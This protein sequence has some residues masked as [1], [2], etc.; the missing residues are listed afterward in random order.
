[1]KKIYINKFA[2]AEE[3]PKLEYVDSLFKRRLSQISRMT[4]QAVHDVLDEAENSKIVFTSFRGELNRQFKINRG[5]VEEF[6]VL[7]AN[8]SISVFN[9][10]PAVATIALKIKAGYTA[11][12]PSEDNF[13][14]A[15]IS[16]CTPI[17]C[18]KEEKIIFVYA[19]EKISEEYQP[20]VH[21]EKTD[22]SALAFSCVLSSEKTSDSIEIEL[23]ENQKCFT[24][25][26]NFLEGLC[27]KN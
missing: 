25:P 10:P 14:S 17:L 24:S 9:T 11:I 26:R 16:A 20:T 13:F 3:T 12:Y 23:D 15:F 19:D 27:Q 7:P 1:M 8:F 5:L 2:V 6:E 18:G 4:I 21:N 22:F